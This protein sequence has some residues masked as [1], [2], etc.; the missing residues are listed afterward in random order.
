MLQEALPFLGLSDVSNWTLLKAGVNWSE[1]VVYFFMN[2]PLDNFGSL[3][4]LFLCQR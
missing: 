1:W 2:V 3:H 4:I